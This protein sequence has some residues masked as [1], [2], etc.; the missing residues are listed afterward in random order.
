MQDVKNKAGHRKQTNL[1]LDVN[2]MQQVRLL[3]LQQQVSA[4]TLVNQ[5][6]TDFLT[7]QK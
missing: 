4:S 7:A 5:I 3:A 2:I 1:M 6:L